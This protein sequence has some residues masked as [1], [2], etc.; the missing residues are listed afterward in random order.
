MSNITRQSGF[1]Q[2]LHSDKPM[3]G[4]FIK[5]PSPIVREIPGARELAISLRRHSRPQF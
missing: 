1:H 3:L 5:T 4:T 2:Q